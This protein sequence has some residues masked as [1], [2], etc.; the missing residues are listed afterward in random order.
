MDICEK[1]GSHTKFIPDYTSLFPSNPY[2][3]DILGLPVINI[4][5]VPLT[6]GFN[7]FVKRNSNFS[8]KRTMLEY[9]TNAI[10]K[11][12]FMLLYKCKEER[13]GQVLTI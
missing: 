10:I 1:S 11:V 4:R 8:V 12:C 13:K 9:F 3:E 6:N 5:F 7:I 2:T